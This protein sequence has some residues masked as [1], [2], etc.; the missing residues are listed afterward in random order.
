MKAIPIVIAVILIA[1]VAVIV[2]GVTG[3]FDCG[4]T[5]TPTPTATPAAT[6]TPTPVLTATPTT[7]VTPTTTPTPT[8]TPTPLT[9]PTVTDISP[10]TFHQGETFRLTFSLENQSPLL[11]ENVYVFCHSISNDSETWI[12]PMPGWSNEVT[13]AAGATAEVT[14]D[15]ITGIDRTPGDYTLEYHVRYTYDGVKYSSE[16]YYPTLSV[17]AANDD[18][19][20]TVSPDTFGQDEQGQFTFLLENHSSSLYEDVYVFCYFVSNDGGS[21]IQPTNQ[22]SDVVV[23]TDG[24]TAEV[25]VDAETN[26]D[27]EVGEYTLSYYI[28]FTGEG[29][30]EFETRY[31]ELVTVQ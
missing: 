13:L 25:T 10:D 12:Q 3:G 9:P 23:L 5:P 8:P 7:T 17:T 19:R 30:R 1:I 4:G 16:H 18:I 24:A 6:P 15:A 2:I 31:E 29:D 22:A 21:W 26:S 20:A 14:V 27:Q 28:H 11:Y